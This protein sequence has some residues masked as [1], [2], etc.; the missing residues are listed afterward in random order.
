MTES[1]Y[2][3]NVIRLNFVGDADAIPL[4]M[5]STLVVRMATF[6]TAGT[7]GVIPP[8]E[9]NDTVSILSPK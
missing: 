3:K 8:G 6:S 7:V 2:S 1:D 5:P 4:T 9:V